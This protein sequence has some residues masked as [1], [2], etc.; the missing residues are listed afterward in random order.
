[1]RD[2][3]YSFTD[4]SSS[5]TFSVV[6]AAGTYLCPNSIDT[7]PLAGYLTELTTNDQPLAPPGAYG[8]TVGNTYRDLGGGE[9]LWLVVDWV[10]A[11]NNLTSCDV[12]LITSASSALG[13]PTIMYDFGVQA[14]AN[15]TGPTQYGK[16][17]Y[18]IA[19]L[20]R[21]TAWLQYL[22][23]QVVT[24]G[25]TSTTG[26]IVAWVGWDISALQLG[27]VSGFSIK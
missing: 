15:L 23:L 25:T 24:A 21:S 5:S 11:P 26:A 13:S 14:I 19:A 17:V 3:Q 7:E 16:G 1:M 9:R 20:P 10:T 6:G 27:G 18:Q 12:Q 22:G 2:Y 8:S 4:T